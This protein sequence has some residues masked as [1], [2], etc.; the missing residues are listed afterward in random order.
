MKSTHTSRTSQ[1]EDN[2]IAI[3]SSDRRIAPVFRV[4]FRTLPTDQNSMSEHM[5]TILDLSV[6]GCRVETAVPVQESGDGI[7]HL[8]P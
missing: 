2:S 5:G 7:T 3:Q 1:L 8:C 4:Q 6:A